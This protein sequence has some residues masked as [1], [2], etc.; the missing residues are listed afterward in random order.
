MR[1]TRLA[2]VM[3]A[4]IVAS[5]V[6]LRAQAGQFKTADEVLERY[7]VVLG[8]VDAIKNVQSETV[9]GEIESTGL[10]GKG[11]FVSYSKPFKSLFK[12]TRSD[13]S[14]VTAGFDGTTSWSVDAKGA[15][16]DK[17]TAAESNRRDADLQYALHQPE[18][19][20]KLELAGITDF[21]GHRFIGC[22]EPPIG[23]KTIISSMTSKPGCS[24][25]TGLRRT[26]RR[27]RSRPL[28]FRTTRASV[29]RW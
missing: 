11:T 5:A 23:A 13:G 7:K 26:M 16:I 29:D 24:S 17:D 18:Y 1:I 22:M 12:L 28:C 10:Q 3:I 2:F 27:R 6:A 15:S 8:G 21:E 4:T 19:F 9:H 25:A 14:L 20:K